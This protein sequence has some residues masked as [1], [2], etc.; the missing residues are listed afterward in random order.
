[1]GHSKKF[2]TFNRAKSQPRMG[3]F[4]LLR[5]FEAEQTT[6]GATSVLILW[7]DVHSS[8]R[9]FYMIRSIICFL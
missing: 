8:E 3:T 1:M 5:P 2:T 9:L 6:F 4:P 7:S